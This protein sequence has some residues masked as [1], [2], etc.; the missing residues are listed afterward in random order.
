MAVFKF[1][2]NDG[3]QSYSVE[4]DQKDCPVF[5]KKIGDKIPGDFLGLAGYELEIRGG[6]DKDGFPMLKNVEGIGKK[7]IILKKGECFSGKKRIKKKLVEIKGLRKRKTVRGNTIT[8]NIMQINCKVVKK[9]EK[10]IEEI[11]GKKE[12][13]KEDKQTEKQKPKEKTDEKQSLTSEENDDSGKKK[14]E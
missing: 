9:G 2:I 6:T 3:K 8:Q 14:E 12:E 7:K 5:E 4:K 10:P 11:F 13:A 1:V